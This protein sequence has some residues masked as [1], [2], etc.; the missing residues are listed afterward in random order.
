MA[1]TAELVAIVAAGIATG[2]SEAS[3]SLVNNA[4]LISKVYFPR[5]I[6]PTATVVVAFV[7]FLIT[8]A[9][10][11]VLMAW[12]QFA[13]GWQMAVLPGFIVLAFVAAMGPALWITALNVRYRDFRYVIPFIVQF[14]LYVSPVGFSTNV[15]P[16]QWRLLYSLNPMVGVIDGFRWC[17][18][19]G[20]SPLYLPG[21][22]VSVLIVGFFLWFGIRRFRK[23]EKS[24]ADLI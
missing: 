15:V 5:L 11:I 4:N 18:L 10:L 9:L 2:L 16:E 6:V 7:D 24:L 3:N 17:I 22:A 14:G 23:T 20:Q 12:Y 8:F 13:P 19:G 1:V 21:L